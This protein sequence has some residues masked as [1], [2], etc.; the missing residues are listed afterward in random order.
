MARVT[1]RY[2]FSDGD[3]LAAQVDVPA[4]YP[5]ALDE[6]R[7]QAVRAFRDAMTEGMAAIADEDDE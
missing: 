6:A 1:I 2:T 3:A 4:S 5:D 7:M